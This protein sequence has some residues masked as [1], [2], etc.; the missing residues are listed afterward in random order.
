MDYSNLPKLI[1]AILSTTIKIH[2]PEDY[3][4]IFKPGLNKS[5]KR[6]LQASVH[7]TNV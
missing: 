2:S 7:K 6:K 3:V 1:I 4:Y 5:I